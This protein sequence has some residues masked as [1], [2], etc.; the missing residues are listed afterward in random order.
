MTVHVTLDTVNTFNAVGVDAV[1]YRA[2]SPPLHATLMD[3]VGAT[4]VDALGAVNNDVVL[5]GALGAMNDDVVLDGAWLLPIFA[6]LNAASIDEDTARSLPLRGSSTC[7]STSNP[8]VI[9]TQDV[10]L[11]LAVAI[12]Q[13]DAQLDDL[14]E[15][16]IQSTGPRSQ[17][18]IH[19]YFNSFISV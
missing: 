15:L 18:K 13:A 3:A 16:D 10:I 6:T 9:M 11:P 5:D 4:L 7:G 14:L 8:A 1:L 2:M 19:S 12:V 17:L